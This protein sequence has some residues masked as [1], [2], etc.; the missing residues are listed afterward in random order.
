MQLAI[1][2]VLLLFIFVWIIL[3]LNKFPWPPRHD[4]LIIK[5]FPKLVVQFLVELYFALLFLAHFE[6]DFELCF[7]IKGDQC[8]VTMMT[9]H[10]Q[11]DYCYMTPGVLQFSSSNKNSR[12]EN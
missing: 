9:W 4:P 7:W 5:D 2:A 11:S 12:P 8:I 1:G 3:Q 6:F 10:Y